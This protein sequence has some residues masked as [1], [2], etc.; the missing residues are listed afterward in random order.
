MTLDHR[1][2]RLEF[3]RSAM[4]FLTYPIQLTVDFPFSFSDWMNDSVSSIE[5]VVLENQRLHEQQLLLRGQL[6]KYHALEAENLRLRRLLRSSFNLGDQILI[7][8]LLRVDLDP[9]KHQ[10]VINKGHR[11]KVRKQQPI[12]DAKGVMGQVVQVHSLSAT[13]MLI[14]DLSHAIP[15]QVNR[16]GL[17]SIAVGTGEL[18]RLNLLHIPNN[19]AIETGDLLVTSGLGGVFPAGYPVAKVTQITRDPSQPFA[20][21][22][23]T[24][25]AELERSREVLLVWPSPKP[26]LSAPAPT[27]PELEVESTPP[28]AGA[29]TPEPAPAAAPSTEQERP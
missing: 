13:A 1:Y 22:S 10:V 24:P 19:A 25:L 11:D 20:T 23:A 29:P 15:V 27:E 4:S 18:N 9:F 6:L 3:I 16:N 8:E 5:S 12:I 2:A 14:T 28:D 21:I 26:L 7:A 17:R